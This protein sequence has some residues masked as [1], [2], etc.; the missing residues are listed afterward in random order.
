MFIR[1][2]IGINPTASGGKIENN[3]KN[4]IVV[5]ANKTTEA[6]NDE[7]TNKIRKPN[8]CEKNKI[9]LYLIMSKI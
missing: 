8:I 9:T 6:A 1:V 2:N 5:T 4:I 7:R 3:I